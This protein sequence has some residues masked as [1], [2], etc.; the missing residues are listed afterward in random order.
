MLTIEAPAKINLT[1]EVLGKRPD[2][3]HEIRSIIQT[4]NLCDTLSFSPRKNIEI[5][6]DLTGWSAEQS[7]VSRAV[8]LFKEATGQNV[9]V[10]IDI[11]KRIPLSSGLAGDSSDAAA[12]LRGLNGLRKTGL[13]QPKLVELA[14]QLGSD[15]SFFLVGGTCLMEGRG[16][17]IT[18]LPPM[19]HRWSVFDYSVCTTI[20]QIKQKQCM[21]AY[22]LRISLTANSPAG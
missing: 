10:M 7:L 14:S 19:P 12:V 8:A 16:E 22:S 20:T 9:G 1:I 17:K 5:K 15:V 13:S 3:Y 18:P 11:Q 21:P 4:I 2:G 6:C